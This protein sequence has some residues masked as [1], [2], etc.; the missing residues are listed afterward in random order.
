M[1]RRAPVIVLSLGAV[2]LAWE[3]ATASGWLPAQLFSSTRGAARSLAVLL[4]SGEWS[5]HV[6]ATLG[7]VLSGF[8]LGLLAGVSLGWLIGAS[9]R[10]GRWLEPWLS[11][12]HP[13]PKIALLPLLLVLFG[14]GQTANVVLAAL[15]AFFP[16]AIS[17]ASGV[18]S[19]EQRY[20]DLARSLDASNT[21][22]L[23]RIV[24]PASLP[25]IFT[26]AR[27]GLN[28]ALTLN[29]AA[30]FV[31]ASD[32]IGQQLWFAWQILDV[33]SVFAWLFT[34]AAFGLLFQIA[35]DRLHRLCSPWAVQPHDSAFRMPRIRQPTA[36]P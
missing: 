24:L 25:A 26:G 12:L 10:A 6:V 19:L 36:S 1:G 8:G 33:D 31:A 35:L 2:L 9:P 15:G 18:R 34:V 23:R 27:I 7:R 20:L 14:L 29:L 28:V 3:L 17:V 21:L 11:A 4:E 5:R 13:L 32:G 22:V 16:V 30:E